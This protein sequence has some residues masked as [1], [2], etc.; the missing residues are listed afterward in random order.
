MR[1]RFL[2]LSAVAVLAG[3]VLAPEARAQ[4][5]A[6][7]DDNTAYGT[8]AAEFLLIAPSARGAALGGGFAALTTDL[9]AVYFNPAGLAQLSQPGIA[10]S[11]M[12]YVA[13]TRYN[14][15]AFAVPFSGGARAIG[16]SVSSFGFGDQREYTVDDPEGTSGE[17]Y[18]VNQTAVGLTLAQQFSDRFS[19]GFTAKFIND[20]LGNTSG[21]AFAVDF[22]TNFHATVGGRALRAGFV[23]QNLG[24][25]LEH[26]G[27]AL[28]AGVIREPP[29]NV[30]PQA[31][32]PAPARLQSKGW[33]LPVLF[34]V[35]LSYDLFTT[36]AS[37]LALMGEFS[38]PNNTEPGFNFGGEYALRLG[39]SGFQ[40]A[41]R[42]SYTYAPDNNLDAPSQTVAGFASSVDDEG[43]D[44]FAAGGGI[45]WQRG[46]GFGLSFDYAYR[47]LGL[48]GGVNM[49]TVGLNW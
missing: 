33:G 48:L 42:A 14:W 28:D 35:S 19:A 13:D 44:G 5:A 6:P 7:R 11:N 10:A 26:S 32:E 3:L 43:L 39:G 22:G 2:V 47:H 12:T 49:I 23:I 41:G 31:Q 37:N 18:S 4:A 25:N 29:E 9:S 24:S 45:R 34:R 20:Q 38:Q 40:I 16:L 30:D 27:Q 1:N 8:T 17:V 21:Q 15:I 36:S 46:R